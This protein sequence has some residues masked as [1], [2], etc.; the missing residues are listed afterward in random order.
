MTTLVKGLGNGEAWE[1][2]TSRS[3]TGD[4]KLFRYRHETRD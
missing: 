2:V 3:T 4:D 1:E